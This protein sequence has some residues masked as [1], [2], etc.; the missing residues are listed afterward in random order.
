MD[1]TIAHALEND[2]TIDITTTGRKSGRPRRVEIWFHNIDGRIY[3]TG[4]P[5]TRD[6]YANLLSD[7]RMT[8]HLKQQVR[9]DLPATARLIVDLEEKRSV[10][11]TI[12]ARLGHS[13]DLDRWLER[14][15]LVE[16]EL[17]GGYVS[18]G[19]VSQS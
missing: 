12:L 9:A 1:Q 8:F 13:E 4:L 15:P 5:G 6:W 7:P 19:G 17:N 14:S 16:V 3:I 10:L 18:S 11:E 2:R